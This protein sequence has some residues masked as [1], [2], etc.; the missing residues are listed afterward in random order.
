LTGIFE[1]IFDHRSM[2]KSW[3]RKCSLRYR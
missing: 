3:N 1:I 2:I